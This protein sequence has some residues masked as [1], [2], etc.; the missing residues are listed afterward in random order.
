MYLASESSGGSV[1]L[2]GRLALLNKSLFSGTKLPNRAVTFGHFEICWEHF[3]AQ[4]MRASVLW[5]PLLSTVV[6]W[7]WWPLIQT[8]T[9]HF[10]HGPLFLFPP[11][12][13]KAP[14]E[15]CAQQSTLPLPHFHFLPLFGSHSKHMNGKNERNLIYW[16]L[17]TKGTVQ[18]RLLSLSASWAEPRIQFL[19]VPSTSEGRHCSTARSMPQERKTLVKGA[20]PLWQ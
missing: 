16:L 6:Q 12:W 4:G 18:T 15:P 9:S 2:S 7:G 1:L 17:G 14:P 8:P 20:E 19:Q 11:Q 10:P 3:L 5:G 13:W